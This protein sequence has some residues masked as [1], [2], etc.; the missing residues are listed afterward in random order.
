VSITVL[1]TD[2]VTGAILIAQDANLDNPFDVVESAIKRSA[3]GALHFQLF[4]DGVCK[5]DE[6]MQAPVHR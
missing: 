4:E 3:G 6:V 5:V 2:T 1:I